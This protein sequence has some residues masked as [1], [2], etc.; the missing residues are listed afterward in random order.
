MNLSLQKL[1][2]F[3][4]SNFQE[5]PVPSDFQKAFDWMAESLSHLDMGDALVDVGRKKGVIDFNVYLD[6]DVFLSVCQSVH[7]QSDEVMYAIGIKDKTLSIGIMR[8]G[9]VVG[10]VL[11]VIQEIKQVNSQ[12]NKND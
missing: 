8:L 5:E 9:E 11:E 12:G 4:L 10:R 3:F 7:E 1:T 6:E 2:N